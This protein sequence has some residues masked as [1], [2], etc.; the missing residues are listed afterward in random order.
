MRKRQGNIA[1][2]T[3][4][5]KFPTLCT[6]TEKSYSLRYMLCYRGWKVPSDGSC[7]TRIF[8]GNLSVILNSQNPA[9][10][11]FKKYVAISFY[12]VREVSVDGI[13]QL[14]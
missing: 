2:S 3:Y 6:A 7:P 13:I 9:D 1:S 14:Y 12:I 5:A 10:D 8:G 4:V 11:L